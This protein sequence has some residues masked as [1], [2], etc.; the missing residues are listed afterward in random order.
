MEKLGL[1][2]KHAKFINW[3]GSNAVTPLQVVNLIN[4]IANRGNVV[5]PTL[6]LDKKI[7]SSKLNISKYVWDVIQNSM[8]DVVNEEIGTAYYLKDE[9]RN[10]Y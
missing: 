8:F 6:F 3:T 9:R 1:K 10:Y 5:K 2:R 7:N 4:I